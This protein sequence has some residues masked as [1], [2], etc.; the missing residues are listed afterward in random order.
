MC[1]GRGQRRPLSGAPP[2]RYSV[3]FDEWD[4]CIADPPV[5]RSSHLGFRVAR[6]L[7]R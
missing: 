3:T 5:Q 1:A 2:G 6:D 4:A 7:R